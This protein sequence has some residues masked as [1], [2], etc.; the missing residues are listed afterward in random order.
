METIIQD[1]EG[2]FVGSPNRSAGSGEAFHKL[3]A[4]LPNLKG[5]K[6]YETFQYSTSALN[7]PT[8]FPGYS[9]Q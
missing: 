9:M 7:T 5:R 3:E 2:M 1:T 6:F 8:R 4:Q